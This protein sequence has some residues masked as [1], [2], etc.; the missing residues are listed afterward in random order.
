[1]RQQIKKI[2]NTFFLL[3]LSIITSFAQGNDD[4]KEH[5]K[6][7]PFTMPVINTPVFPDRSVNIKDCG[8]VGDGQTMNTDAFKKAI[9]QCA[10]Q[11]GGA[12]IVPPGLW[13]TGP[14]LFKSNINLHLEKGAL[15]IFSKNH[16]DYTTRTEGNSIKVN[17][18]ISGYN[19]NNIAITGD[20]IF[21]GSGDT[22]R[23][24][25][26]VKVTE[27][28]WKKLI[29]S[30]GTVGNEN[31]YW[32]PQKDKNIEKKRP[33]MVMFAKCKQVL[34][35]GPTFQN[36]PMF[37]INPHFC[38]NMIIR[39]IKVLNE[40]WA[41]NGDGIDISGGKNIM[42]YNCLV[43]A[44]DDGICMKSSRNNKYNGN[45]CL[46]NIVISDCV[47]YHAHGG[48]VIGSNTDGGMKNIAV[49]NCNFIYTDVGLRFKSARGR[50]GLVENIYIK[51][52][53]MKDIAREAILFNTY[54]ENNQTQK[55]KYEVNETTPR[56]QKFF[57]QNIYCNNAKQ[58]ID[59]T[60]LPEMPIQNINLSNIV[61]SARHGISSIDT[62]NIHMNKVHILPEK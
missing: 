37:V 38:E 49:N 62:K 11:G 15:V 18:L 12:V 27:D 16:Q 24:V 53:F 43:N 48:F 9:D 32:P 4:V 1:M 3:L 42:I 30:G 28:Q 26:K 46:Q 13:L 33:Y 55:M 61:I 44:G 41:Q 36:S 5:L 25:K 54:Y 52:I 6:D 21:D 39:N 47:V 2:A 8:A 22:W 57:L 29:A 51:N 40:W 50:G 45:A 56:F 7:L 19:L 10:S 23:P 58:A 14:I 59:I 20:G 34:L 35:D 60:G 17:P 31:I